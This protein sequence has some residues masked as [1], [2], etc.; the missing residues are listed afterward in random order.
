MDSVPSLTYPGNS[1]D[2][3]ALSGWLFHRL[4]LCYQLQSIER[5]MYVLL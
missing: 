5:N 3:I 1:Y 2:I 4:C